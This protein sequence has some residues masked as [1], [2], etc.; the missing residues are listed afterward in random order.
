MKRVKGINWSELVREQIREVAQRRLR[1][2]KVKALLAA[3]GFSRE[4]AE[5]FDSTEVIRF[6]RERRYGPVRG[7]R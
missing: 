7:R 2:N 4:P 3:Q 6:W 5:G 1:K